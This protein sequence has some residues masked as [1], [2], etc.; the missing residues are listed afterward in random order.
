MVV[1]RA[2]VAGGPQINRDRGLCGVDLTCR[3]ASRPEA[4]VPLYPSV[5]L[6]VCPHLGLCPAAAYKPPGLKLSASLLPP[7]AA[8]RIEVALAEARTEAA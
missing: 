3:D 8:T 6:S 7:G 2:P 4:E 5:D 1:A